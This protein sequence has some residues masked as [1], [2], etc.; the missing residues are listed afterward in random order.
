M[1]NNY[2]LKINN[3]EVPEFYTIP[4]SYQ[5]PK[6]E[7]IIDDYYDGNYDRH[8]IKSVKKDE[9]IKVTLR[10]LKNTEYPTVIAPFLADTL[11][12]EYYNP[13]TDSYLSDNFTLV[14]NVEPQIDVISNGVVWYQEIEL[15]L[16]KV[17][18]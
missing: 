14:S 4:S 18:S 5:P 6:T 10:K 3:V 15:E 8:I 11:T 17:V 7:I 13:V 16:V 12:V 9:G 1:Y 2:L